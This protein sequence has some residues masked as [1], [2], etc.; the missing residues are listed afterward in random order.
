MRHNNAAANSFVSFDHGLPQ[1]VSGKA[2]DH[3][4]GWGVALGSPFMFETSTLR[5]DYRSDIYRER[6]ILLG[7]VHEIVES[8][9]CVT[10]A[11]E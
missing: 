8:L 11:R 3:A 1:D 9:F 7:A 5:S 2:T 4:L 6:G 10:L